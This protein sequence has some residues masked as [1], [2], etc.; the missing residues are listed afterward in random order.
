VRTF[1]DEEGRGWDV[2]AGRESWGAIV[3]IFIPGR[4]GAQV[5]QTVLHASGH[6]EATAELASLDESRLRDL[7]RESQPKNP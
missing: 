2:V 5:R 1:R 6:V 7:L 3:A 4:R